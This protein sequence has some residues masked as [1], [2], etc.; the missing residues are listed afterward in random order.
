MEW[1]LALKTAIQTARL[2]ECR[3]LGGGDECNAPFAMW[4]GQQEDIDEAVRIA[5]DVDAC[6]RK[7]GFSAPSCIDLA[8]AGGAAV[9][10]ERGAP[11]EASALAIGAIA[12][13]DPIIVLCHNP[14]VAGDH[15]ACGKAG[16]VARPGDL[17]Y[18]IVLNVESP[19]T[20]SPWGIMVDGNDPLTGEKVAG[21]M[22]VWTHATDIAAQQVVDLVR[23]I[24]GE[25]TTEQITNGSYVRDWAGASRLGSAAGL[26]LLS[27]GEVLR[28]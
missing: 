27:S 24:N 3:R 7:S 2:T 17:R 10:E 22:N 1:D 12:A 9:A 14:V 21:S 20:P 15:A 26:P 4:T 18:N 16:L 6:R 13:M 5:R 25:L 19:Q 11:D 23:Y 28:A 8:R